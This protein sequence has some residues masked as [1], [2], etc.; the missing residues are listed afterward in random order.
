[1]EQELLHEEQEVE[2]EVPPPSMQRWARCQTR[3]VAIG[4]NRWR[5][6]SWVVG[7]MPDAVGVINFCH[8]AK[9]TVVPNW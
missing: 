9:K 4:P 8:K 5:C 6:T 3:P 2:G 1:M 7:M